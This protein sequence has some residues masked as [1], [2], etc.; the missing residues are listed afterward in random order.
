MLINKPIMKSLSL[1]FIVLF[2]NIPFAMS[3]QKFESDTLRTSAGPLTMTFVGHGTLMFSWNGL[4][5][6][7]DPVSQYADYEALPDADLI[8]VTHHHGDHLDPGAIA[9]LSKEGTTVICSE[10]CLEKLPDALVMKNGD[11][12][13]FKGLTISAVPAYNIEHRRSNGEPFHPKGVGNGYVIDFGDK[14]VYVAGDTENIP[15]MAELKDIRCAFL[16]MN[17]PYTMSPEMVS[18]AVR[19]FHPAILYPYHY[20][21]TDVSKLL[22]LLKDESSCE[23]R[24]RNLQ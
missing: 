2:L 20:G 12:R 10:S 7:I 17:L 9:Q 18:Q 11:V 23:I 5:I 19:M 24:I 21:T 4:T 14:K 6:H 13:S 15:E 22:D 8:L 3:Q 1:F 16:P